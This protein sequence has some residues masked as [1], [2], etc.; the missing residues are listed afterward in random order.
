ML[1]ANES[2][3]KFNEMASDDSDTPFTQSGSSL[4]I[5][6]SRIVRFVLAQSESQSCNTVI[7]RAK[8]LQS[9]REISE[10]EKQKPCSFNSIYEFVDSKLNDIFGYH[11]FGLEARSQ[12]KPGSKKRKHSGEV[13]HEVEEPQYSQINDVR[14]KGHTFVLIRNKT[15][16]P[17]RYSQFLLD[18]GASIYRSRIINEAYIGT[19]YRTDFQPTLENSFG[20]DQQLALRGITAISVCLVV[21]S[22]NNILESELFEQYKKFGIP[23]DGHEIPIVQMTVTEL[24]SFLVRHSYLSRIVEKA[25]DSAQDITIYKIGRRAQIEFPKCSL[26]QLCQQF[27]GLPAD[28]SQILQKT[29]E[30]LVGDA[31]TDN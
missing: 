5:I 3:T 16:A 9:I 20:A 19:D 26:I 22:K 2:S 28:Q 29:I 8:I 7:S 6:G 10:E 24:L 12:T 11:L 14:S 15:T 25:T 21:L 23:C 30:V 18:Y 17:P 4:E 13:E 27:L 31:Y 1:L